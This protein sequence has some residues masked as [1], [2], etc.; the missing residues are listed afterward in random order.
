[1]IQHETERRVA[2]LVSIAEPLLQAGVR[3]CLANEADMEV[4]D[5][6]PV[7][8]QQSVDVVV[9]DSSTAPRSRTTAGSSVSKA[10]GRPASWS[11]PERLASMP[12][13]VAWSRA[14]T[15]RAGQFS[16]QR[17][18]SGIRALSRGGNYLCA[19]AAQQL[20]PGCRA[21][22]SGRAVK[23]RFFGFLARGPVQQINCT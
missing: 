17:T 12:F 7:S 9:A 21:G 5:A 20:A 23:T 6:N 18:L 2:V 11:S 4:I 3:A 1:M 14:F 19:P 10:S 22:H 15:L 8:A 13:E 16:H